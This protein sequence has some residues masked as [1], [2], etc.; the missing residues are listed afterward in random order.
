M[1]SWMAALGKRAERV[2]V[3]GG[4]FLCNAADHRVA[5]KEFFVALIFSTATFWLSAWLMLFLILGEE[6]QSFLGNL[7]STVENGELLIFAVGFIGSTLIVAFD[8]PTD[9]RQFPGKLWHAISLFV[10]G[11]LCAA[12][13]GLVR[14]SGQIGGAIVVN[15]QMLFAASIWLSILACILRYLAI[16]YRKFTL[17]PDAAMKGGEVGFA[18]EFAARH[19]GNVQ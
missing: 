8:D 18:N 7:K 6:E 10:L 11:L 3:F 14:L 9:A 16:V 5:A 1:A 19:R 13:F 2:P 17:R 12:A 15:G 4:L